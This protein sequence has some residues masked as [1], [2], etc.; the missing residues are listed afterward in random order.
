MLSSSQPATIPCITPCQILPTLRRFEVGQAAG[1]RRAA[2][3]PNPQAT[4][5]S[6][7]LVAAM[8]PCIFPPRNDFQTLYYT[9]SSS[10]QP[11]T[12]SRHRGAANLG[13][14]RLFK[15]AFVSGCT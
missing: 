4:R 14:S 1:L 11:A 6:E 13:R 3:P 9:L 5:R 15:A 10:S 2:G 12:I 8:L 7:A